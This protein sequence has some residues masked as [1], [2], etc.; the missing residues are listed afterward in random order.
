MSISRVRWSACSVLA[1]VVL[2]SG[3]TL[4]GADDPRPVVDD[5]KTPVQ[6]AANPNMSTLFLVG[7]FVLVEFGHNDAGIYK[8]PKAKGA[9]PI[10]L[11]MVP[12]KPDPPRAGNFG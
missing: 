4:R 7:D 8:D 5:S 9:T 1:I 12:L 10:W 11:S 2:T 6:T 3:P